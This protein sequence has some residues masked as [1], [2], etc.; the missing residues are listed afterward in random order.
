MN[1]DQLKD[2]PETRKVKA[3]DMK[4][5]MF[6]MLLKQPVLISQVNVSD[7][8]DDRTDK[9]LVIGEEVFTGNDVELEFRGDDIIDEP[10][11]ETKDYRFVSF[12]DD[13]HLELRLKGGKIRKDIKL[14]KKGKMG[15]IREDI[16]KYMH[17]GKPLIVS[18]AKFGN[19][20]FPFSVVKNTMHA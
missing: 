10:L 2:M 6:M 3:K 16:S 9:V 12:E 11:V 4:S 7:G 13:D 15:R 8:P 5:G 14:G 1:N 20:E 19:Y 18:C 17:E